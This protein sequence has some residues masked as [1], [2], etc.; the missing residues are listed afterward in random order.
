MSELDV[1]SKPTV[2][3]VVS[4]V[5]P[6]RPN[7]TTF[8]PS[9]SVAGSSAALAGADAGDS[10]GNP[11][12]VC[13]HWSNWHCAGVIAVCV[14]QSAGSG[15]P[16]RLKSMC[17]VCGFTTSAV[18]CG[19]RGGAA[20]R[21]NCIAVGAGPLEPT[22]GVQAPSTAS[23]TADPPTTHALVFRRFMAAPRSRRSDLAATRTPPG[24]SARRSPWAGRW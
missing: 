24:C 11:S 19:T 22:S 8:V 4:G 14:V 18:G 23:A 2:R 21:S 20:V 9:V 10:D 12:S 7:T 6:G 13:S 17:P 1:A 16:A 15:V 3:P 5:L